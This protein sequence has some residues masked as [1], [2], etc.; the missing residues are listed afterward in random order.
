MDSFTSTNSETI[1]EFLSLQLLFTNKD[2]QSSIFTKEQMKHLALIPTHVKTKSR[3]VLN[4]SFLKE[5][6]WAFV[7]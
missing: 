3:L 1:T 4:S 5:D 2:R 7:L 6:E